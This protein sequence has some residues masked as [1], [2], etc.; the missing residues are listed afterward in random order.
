MRGSNFVKDIHCLPIYLNVY[1]KIWKNIYKN[2]PETLQNSCE[3][4]F[5]QKKGSMTR[6]VVPAI[7]GSRPVIAF[8]PCDLAVVRVIIYL[9]CTRSIPQPSSHLHDTSRSGTLSSQEVCPHSKSRA[10]MGNGLTTARQEGHGSRGKFYSPMIS[11]FRSYFLYCWQIPDS[12][13][14]FNCYPSV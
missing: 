14:C 8:F 10:W 9:S 11:D 5:D 1:L 6:K 13:P 4:P 3:S 2:V 7:P 12:D